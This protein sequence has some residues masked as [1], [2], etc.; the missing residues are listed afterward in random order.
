VIILLSLILVISSPVLNAEVMFEMPLASQYEGRVG[1]VMMQ[2]AKHLKLE[3]GNSF[4]LG[5]ISGDEDFKMNWGGDF[6]TFTRLRS[7]GNF[8]FPVETTDYY[9]GLNTTAQF[10]LWN[11]KWDARLRLGHISAH[12]IDGYSNYQEKFS[13]PF[14][15]S[16]EFIDLLLMMNISEDL[17]IYGGM[18][19]II[20]TIPDEINLIEPQFG[21]DYKLNI[22]NERIDFI[23]GYDFRM[24][25]SRSRSSVKIETY[26]NNTFKAGLEFKTWDDLGIRLLYYGYD[27]MSEHGMF[28][29]KKISLSNSHSLAIELKYY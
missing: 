26:Y 27:G 7:E 15:Y 17:R 16:R 5:Q 29:G 8:K 25:G 21:F 23:V 14:V 24:V 28:L 2:K 19:F 12:I 22:L 1:V 9:F 13:D 20:S 6:F 11:Y 3:L 4:D 10:N 18:N